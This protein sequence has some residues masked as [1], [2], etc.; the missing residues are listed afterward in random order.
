MHIY[1]DYLDLYIFNV[2]FFHLYFF[3]QS[4]K[5]PI[6]AAFLFPM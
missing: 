5:V 1:E 4:A 3:L 6:S 2:F